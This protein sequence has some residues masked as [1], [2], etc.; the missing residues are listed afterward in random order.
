MCEPQP[1][2]HPSKEMWKAFN[3]LVKKS[4]T[5]RVADVEKITG[6]DYF[7]MLNARHMT[8][9]AKLNRV[10]TWCQKTRCFEVTPR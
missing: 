8:N 7:G 10:I 3:A 1:T 5:F 4:S 6:T 9:A 2:S